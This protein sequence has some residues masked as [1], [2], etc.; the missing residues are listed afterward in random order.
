MA[1]TVLGSRESK[2]CQDAAKSEILVQ[3]MCLLFH[4]WVAEASCAGIQAGDEGERERE[5]KH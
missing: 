3:Q 4:V 1:L 2:V 5:K